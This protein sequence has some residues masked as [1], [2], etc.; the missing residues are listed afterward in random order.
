MDGYLI[1]WVAGALITWWSLERSELSR[2]VK[3]EFFSATVV[4]WPLV[5]AVGA[6]AGLFILC[7]K[8]F[9]FITGGSK[10]G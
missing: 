3:P 9:R 2:K 6:L 8:F 4:L 1:V 7:R 5:W 10:L